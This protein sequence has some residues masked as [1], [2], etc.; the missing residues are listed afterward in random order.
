[1]TVTPL[2]ALGQVGLKSEQKDDIKVVLQQKFARIDI[3]ST[4]FIEQMPVYIQD[5]AT[6]ITG[7][8]GN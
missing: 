1:M 8:I 3:H 7:K 4:Q 2:S 5:R 6:K